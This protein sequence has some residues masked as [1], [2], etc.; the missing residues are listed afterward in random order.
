MRVP[1]MIMAELRRLTGGGMSRLALAALLMGAV[2]WWVSE[3]RR[4]P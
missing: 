3:A 2:V 4:A 1:A